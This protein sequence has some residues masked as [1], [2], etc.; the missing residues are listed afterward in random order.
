MPAQRDPHDAPAIRAFG[1]TLKKMRDAAELAQKEFGETLGY[2]PQFIG[3]IESA[4]NIPSKTFA[5]DLDTYF[6][7][8]GLFLEL[9]NLIK[10]ARRLGMSP[11]GFSKYVELERSAT[12][13]RVFESRFI[14]ALFEAGDDARVLDRPNLPHVFLVIDEEALRRKEGPAE[15]TGDRFAHLLRLTE[16]P[17]ICVQVLAHDTDYPAAH[18]GSFTV[19]GFDGDSDVVYIESAGLGSLIDT[20][21]AV[22]SCA[23][24]FDLLRGHAYSVTESRSILER[25][26]AA[27]SPDSRSPSS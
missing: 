18:A 2:S 26:L 20:P 7:L 23:M 16:R 24:R 11:A 10:D 12:T 15:V 3:Q 17:E 25:S 8:D 6:K 22:A 4:R 5:Q 13:M 27:Y 14:P 1:I 21:S 9:W 19:L